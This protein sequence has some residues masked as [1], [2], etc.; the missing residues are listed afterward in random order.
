MPE[1]EHESYSKA[2]KEAKAVL[3]ISDTVISNIMDNYKKGEGPYMKAEQVRP[4]LE[5]FRKTLGLYKRTIKR[6]KE[7]EWSEKEAKGAA[8]MLADSAENVAKKIEPLDK[9]EARR[10][11]E[12][13][14]YLKHA[15]QRE[16][17]KATA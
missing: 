6:V 4:K 17:Q 8:N 15:Y 1:S 16:K 12:L 13:S 5:S 7:G 11:E 2:S 10:F 3:K 14:E 9:A